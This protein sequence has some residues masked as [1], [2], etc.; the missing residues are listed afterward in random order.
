MNFQKTYSK[1]SFSRSWK[2]I[3]HARE[4][5]ARIEDGMAERF[6]YLLR[7][8]NR[9]VNYWGRDIRDIKM[10][11]IG[12]GQNMERA[13]YF[14]RCNQV[15]ATD[16]DVVPIGF[17]V[18]GYWLLMKQ[19]GFG[20]LVKTVGRKI[21]LGRAE[22]RAWGTVVGNAKL[23]YPEVRQG[24]IC[25]DDPISNDFDVVI[26]WATFEHVPDPESALRYVI[27]SLK[28]NGVLYISLH[29][30][31]SNDGHHNIESLIGNIDKLPP[32]GHLRPS[33]RH[34]VEPHCY[35][36]RWDLAQWR[37]LFSKFAPGH[38]EF[39]DTLGHKA[40]FS[41]LLT[42]EVISTMD[43][44]YSHEELLYPQ[45]VYLWQKPDN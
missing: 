32:W 3:A 16:L 29:L 30:Y 45:L 35:V 10:L 31:T 22:N 26:S 1:F 38:K 2:Q 9:I 34:L 37:N 7:D 20:R 14:A 23:P 39:L 19:N 40:R 43:R 18:K 36:N 6:D 13:R 27:N 11:E 25:T 5:T 42:D 8:E 15:I 28:P 33:I 44:D 24:N 4:K 21:L 12:A 41:H 17:D